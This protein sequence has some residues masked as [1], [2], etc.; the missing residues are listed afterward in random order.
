MAVITERLRVER[1]VFGYPGRVVG[2]DVSFSLAAGQVLCLLGPN[3]SGKTTLFRTLL[4]LLEP[5]GGGV[6]VDGASIA[7]WPRRRLA[8]VF[9]YVPQ[10]Q[11]GTFPFTAREV[12]LMGRTAHVGL[13]GAPSAHDRRQADAA[14]EALGIAHLADRPYPE[15]SGGERQLALV[16]RALAQDPT[17]LIM[18]EPTASLDFGNQVRVL[19]HVQSLARRGIAIVLSTHDPDQTFLCADLVALLHEGRLAR[20]GPPADV[21]TAATLREIYGVDVE[22]VTVTREGRQARVCLPSLGRRPD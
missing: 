17:I 18:D 14:L 5:Q 10:A 13:F 4:R 9:G 6:Q 20:L 21:I 19:A 16:A 2:R 15:M 1:L 12:V 7:E 3:G 11:L 8:R 22:V